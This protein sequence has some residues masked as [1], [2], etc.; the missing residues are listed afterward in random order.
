[1]A[2]AAIVQMIKQ[3]VSDT[4]SG[5]AKPMEAWADTKAKT[6][7]AENGGT[8][9]STPISS[10][11]AT[12][13]GSSGA[14]LNVGSVVDL[15]GKSG[16][17]EAASGAGEA[18]SGAGSALSS[19]GSSGSG[20]SSLVSSLSDENA[21]E[22]VETSNE[23]EAAR[24]KAEQ[25]ADINAVVMRAA[26][27][28]ASKKQED[29]AAKAQ[30]KS[31][32]EASSPA[33]TPKPAPISTTAPATATAGMT[34]QQAKDFHN[35][36]STIRGVAEG[37]AKPFEGWTAAKTGRA[38]KFD[39]GTNVDKNTILDTLAGIKEGQTATSDEKF[40]ENIQPSFTKMRYLVRQMRGAK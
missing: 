22:N 17:S 36:T 19:L 34:D 21:K 4:A 16:S 13:S 6:M 20:I 24:I 11:P 25:D 9:S 29:T 5:I 23:D 1:M 8:V 28:Q 2:W 12:S 10:K 18:A 26:A 35:T 32:V 33:T 31:S 3:G 15:L 7:A 38:P 14:G 39:A 40:K 37:V 27:E 30:T